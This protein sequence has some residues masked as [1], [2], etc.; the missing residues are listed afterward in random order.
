[1]AKGCVLTTGYL[2]WG[3]L[4][5]N[6]VDRITDCPNMTLAVDRGRKASTQKKPDGVSNSI[7]TALIALVLNHC[8]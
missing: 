3:G 1:M 7:Y 6:S 2:P 5:R 8:L 4:P